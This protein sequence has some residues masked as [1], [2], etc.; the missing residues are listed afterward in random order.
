MYHDIFLLLHTNTDQTSISSRK[1]LV[2]TLAW[3]DTRH[4]KTKVKQEIPLNIYLYQ[5]RLLLV[6]YELPSLLLIF[7]LSLSFFFPKCQSVNR[8][9]PSNAILWHCHFLTFIIY[10]SQWSMEKNHVISHLW[11]HCFFYVNFDTF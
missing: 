7:F 9:V 8:S 5:Q 4:A 10:Y 1:Y 2:W 6:I 11:K 3:A